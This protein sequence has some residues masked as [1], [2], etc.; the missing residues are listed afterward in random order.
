MFDGPLLPDD[1]AAVAFV[2]QMID[3]ENL[4]SLLGT[5]GKVT[6]APNALDLQLAEGGVEFRDVVFGYER[7][8]SVLKGVS[9]WFSH[10]STRELAL[11][12]CVWLSGVLGPRLDVQVRWQLGAAAIANRCAKHVASVQEPALLAETSPLIPVLWCCC[13][14]GV[15]QGPWR[16]HCGLRWCNRQRQVDSHE[17]AVQVGGGV[18]SAELVTPG[19][20]GVR[21]GC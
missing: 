10:S 6:D 19:V 7:G 5:P 18:E 17:A 13:A 1:A 8:V 2:L 15:F 16:Q 12:F 14:P 4:L 20:G 11:L 9:G 21:G 3:M